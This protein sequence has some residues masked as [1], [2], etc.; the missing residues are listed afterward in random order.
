MSIPA[1]Q[2]W[3]RPPK[4]AIIGTTIL[5][6]DRAHST[7]L[8]CPE[9]EAPTARPCTNPQLPTNDRDLHYAVH[10]A[11]PTVAVAVRVYRPDAGG[12]FDTVA[13][14]DHNAQT[15]ALMHRQL[16]ESHPCR[17]PGCDTTA[18]VPAIANGP[19]R[20]AGVD[21]LPGDVVDFCPDHFGEVLGAY[22]A[23]SRDDMPDWLAVDAKPTN[24]D[25]WGELLNAPTVEAAQA[26]S[27]ELRRRGVTVTGAELTA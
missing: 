13:R 3:A 20:L 14:L 22:M 6:P 11:R 15:R 5:D 24:S 27:A 21:W 12:S 10:E 25:L 23:V 16:H 2:P 9:C 19:G 18:R 8:A 4:F 7:V 26:L 17:R 1:Q